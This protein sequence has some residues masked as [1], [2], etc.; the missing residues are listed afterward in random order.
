MMCV[1]HKMISILRRYRA[2]FKTVKNMYS[3]YKYNSNTHTLT[4]VTTHPGIWVGRCGQNAFHLK[5]ELWDIDPE[6]KLAFEEAQ[7]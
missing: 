6:L 1:P 7:V 3:V 5:M 2:Q 4:I